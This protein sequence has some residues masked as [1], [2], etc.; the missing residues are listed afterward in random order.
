MPGSA[1]MPHLLRVRYLM[2]TRRLRAPERR[3]QILKCATQVFARSNFRSAT[4]KQIAVELGIS[5]AAIFN[6]FPTKRDIF[7]AILDHVN[8]QI[9]LRWEEQIAASEDAATKLREIGIGYFRSMK[10]HPDELKVQ[11][12]AVAEIDDP[13]IASRL[14]E[15]HQCYLD[16]VERLILQGIK[17]G[18]FPPETQALSIAYIFDSL[19]VFS[20]LMNLLD[21]EQFDVPE[22][23]RIMD[24]LLSPLI[25]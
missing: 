10:E 4:T 22:A 20:N 16:S 6:H 9:L 1:P 24:H 13:A 11:F 23:N 15:H 7:L 25:Q 17:V 21:V 12:Q 2:V 14:K 5:E 18:E 8:A 19:G 3:K